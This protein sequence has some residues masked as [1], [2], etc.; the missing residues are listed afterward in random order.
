MT[1]ANDRITSNRDGTLIVRLLLPA[2]VGKEETERVTIRPVL[3]GDMR[4]ISGVTQ[5]NLDSMMDM[6]ARLAS[7]K[8]VVEVL[9]CQADLDAVLEAAMKQVLAFQEP[10]SGARQSGSSDESS[11]SP[12][13]SSTS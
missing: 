3:S 7:P 13:P 4:T 5:A 11:T 10:G 1:E 12:A 2:K 9:E 6:A 8:G